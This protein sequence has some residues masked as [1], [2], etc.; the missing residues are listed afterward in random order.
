MKP[1]LAAIRLY[2]AVDRVLESI[3]PALE[4]HIAEWPTRDSLSGRPR[5]ELLEQHPAAFGDLLDLV[6]RE[7]GELVAIA[8]GA[9]GELT[10][11]DCTKMEAFLSWK[12]AKGPNKPNFD[13]W[14]TLSHEE[15]GAFDPTIF[16]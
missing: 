4:T 13:V 3:D 9:G 15:I 7:G 1:E 16:C 10:A 12:S 5:R 2:A 14:L 11:A 8:A 6:A